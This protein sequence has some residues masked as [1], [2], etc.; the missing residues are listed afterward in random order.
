M[1]YELCLSGWWEHKLFLTLCEFWRFFH[2]LFL[3]CSPPQPLVVPFYTCV[4]QLSAKESRELCAHLWKTLFF[5]TLSCKLNSRR[6]PGF[7]RILHPCVAA[8]I[9]LEQQA[10]A[11]RGLSS[12]VY[13]LSGIT[14]LRYLMSNVWKLLFH[15]FFPFKKWFRGLVIPFWMEAEIQNKHFLICIIKV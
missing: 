1:N 7:I 9:F 12:L 10:G 3:G 8:R 2:L 6:S 13:N 4:D 14:T 15:L 5:S 11:V